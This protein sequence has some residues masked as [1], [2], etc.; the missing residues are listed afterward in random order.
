M[1]YTRY[2][3]F[4]MLLR[5]T[6]SVRKYY[7]HFKGSNQVS[8]KQDFE[9]RKYL[10]ILLQHTYVH[11]TYTS[12]RNVTCNFLQTMKTYQNNSV[13]NLILLAEI[14]QSIQNV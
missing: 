11:G 2:N 14:I 7:T 5:I 1:V 13:Q 10:F 12:I 8:R 3:F 4:I 9:Q 6:H